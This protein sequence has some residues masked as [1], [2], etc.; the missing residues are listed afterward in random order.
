MPQSVRTEVYQGYADDGK[1]FEAYSPKELDSLI[2]AYEAS[3]EYQQKKASLSSGIKSSLAAQSNTIAPYKSRSVKDLFTDPKSAASLL[4][5]VGTALPAGRTAAVLG[6]GIQLLANTVN[7]PQWGDSVAN[8]VAGGL[9][10]VL[11]KF[12]PLAINT[13]REG[14][15]L[16]R[17]RESLKGTVRGAIEGGAA[18][19]SAEGTDAVLGENKYTSNL[20]GSLLL[21]GAIGGA[22]G[23][24][25]PERYK[26]TVGRDSAAEVNKLMKQKVPFREGLEAA[27]NEFGKLSRKEAS[28]AGTWEA[29]KEADVL[30][31]RQE[32]VELE[33]AK[34]LINDEMEKLKKNIMLDP[35]YEFKMS[36][37]EEMMLKADEG[38]NETR[39]KLAE[40]TDKKLKDSE[41]LDKLLLEMDEWTKGLED[42]KE[43]R[44]GTPRTKLR[45]VNKRLEE[46]D[47]LLANL[48]TTNRMSKILPSQMEL[49]N[50]AKFKLEEYYPNFVQKWGKNADSQFAKVAGAKGI[51]P[52]KFT[53]ETQDQVNS[54][55]K[56]LQDSLDPETVSKIRGTRTAEEL[57]NKELAQMASLKEERVKLLNERKAHEDAMASIEEDIRSGRI[58]PQIKK[59]LDLYESNLALGKT[60]E[61]EIRSRLEEYNKTIGEGEDAIEKLSEE[62]NTSKTDKADTERLQAQYKDNFMSLYPEFEAKSK[63]ILAL[64]SRIDQIK[65]LPLPEQEALFS[66][67]EAAK[68]KA[69]EYAKAERAIDDSID[70]IV[71]SLKDEA[72]KK[73]L[74][75]MVNSDVSGAFRTLAA[76]SG[77]ALPLKAIMAIKL[78]D[79][80]GNPNMQKRVREAASVAVGKVPGLFGVTKR[81]LTPVIVNRNKNKEELQ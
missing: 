22:A 33:N 72:A 8:V 56:L 34:G 29:Q 20:G 75:T 76:V 3:P 81:A 69:V 23:W 78:V 73:K 65:A 40:T 35:D 39:V 62:F 60:R 67:K 74:G 27:E 80:F 32:L 47:S 1:M 64:Q 37:L 66:A 70:E 2:E 57:Y 28:L 24:A 30:P 21:G 49:E 71:N 46:V 13:A 9:G 77:A 51:L 41:A 26:A 61:K 58:N 16:P 6:G 50:L 38:I 43:S 25:E 7:Q 14:R 42:T 59:K 4:T 18:D 52:A 15:I 48:E 17:L 63:E 36:K 12:G 19:L 54:F 68:D 55:V 11:S 44:L 53:P 79:E 10:N 45:T 31:L 5:A